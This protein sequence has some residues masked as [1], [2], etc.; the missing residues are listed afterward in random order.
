[1]QLEFAKWASRRSENARST[2]SANNAPDDNFLFMELTSDLESPDLSDLTHRQMRNVIMSRHKCN[3]QYV[4]GELPSQF[5][6]GLTHHADCVSKCVHD[7][8][9]WINWMGCTSNIQDLALHRA[10][11]PRKLRQP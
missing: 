6:A 10:T 2:P 11:Y 5:A 8:E 9:T 4:V 1:M 7:L 3:S